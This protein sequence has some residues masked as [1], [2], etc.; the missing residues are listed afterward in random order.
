MSIAAML[1]SRQRPSAD[2]AT[3]PIFGGMT[4]GLR[5]IGRMEGERI[6]PTSIGHLV[7]LARRRSSTASSC[8]A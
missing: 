2:I 5:L 3:N 1:E 8:A 4:N 6:P 7:P